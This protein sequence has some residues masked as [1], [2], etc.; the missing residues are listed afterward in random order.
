MKRPPDLKQL[1]AWVDSHSWS[2]D[3]SL[4]RSTECSVNCQPI[5][6][7]SFS[8]FSVTLATVFGDTKWSMLSKFSAFS[9]ALIVP[10]LTSVA[11]AKSFCDILSRVLAEIIWYPLADF[12]TLIIAILSFIARKMFTIAI[13]LSI[14]AISLAKNARHKKSGQVLPTL[15]AFY[16][17]NLKEKTMHAHQYS[18]SGFKN[19]PKWTKKNPILGLNC[20][21]AQVL[22]GAA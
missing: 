21:T 10:I 7:S 12:I 18:Q 9:I 20:K 2:P 19:H 5:A 1:V 17:V 16:M 4:M 22:G 15:T 11:S 14:I 13:I 6:A 3:F 8:A